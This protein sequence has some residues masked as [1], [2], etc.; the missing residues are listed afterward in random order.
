MMKASDTCSVRFRLRFCGS[1]W[2]ALVGLLVCGLVG[3]RGAGAQE[4]PVEG[5]GPWNVVTLAD[6]PGVTEPQ[7]AEWPRTKVSAEAVPAAVL[8]GKGKWTLAFWFKGDEAPSRSGLTPL[9]GIGD[10]MA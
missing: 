3:T 1:P 4:I 10:A 9:A 7:P 5:Y 6:G 8:E 2:L